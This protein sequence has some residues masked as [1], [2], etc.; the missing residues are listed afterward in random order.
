M[1][2]K[3]K[4]KIP[5]YKTY[6]TSEGFGSP[7]QWRSDFFQ[8]MGF[9]EAKLIIKNKSPYDIIGVSRSDSK[10]IAQAAFWKL[11]KLHHPDTGGSTEKMQEINAAWSLICDSF[12]K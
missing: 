10:Q 1:P 9:E 4:F 11:A 2:P 6:D 12:F 5:T 3:R 8:R 7:D